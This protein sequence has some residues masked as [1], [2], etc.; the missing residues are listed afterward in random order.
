MY[1]PV[2]SALLFSAMYRQIS[3][4]LRKQGKVVPVLN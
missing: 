2:I 1:L 3:E 4:M